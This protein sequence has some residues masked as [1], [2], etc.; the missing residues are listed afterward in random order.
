MREA[1]PSETSPSSQ[2]AAG[3]ALSCPAPASRP[4]YVDA[5]GNLTVR[6]RGRFCMWP[7]YPQG[8]SPVHGSQQH[9]EDAETLVSQFPQRQSRCVVFTCLFT[10]FAYQRAHGIPLGEDSEGHL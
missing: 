4:T 9:L 8:Q 5:D 6:C 10:H 3:Q 1:V 7:V 2:A